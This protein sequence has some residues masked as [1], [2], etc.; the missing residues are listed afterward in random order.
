METGSV[1]DP[2]ENPTPAAISE[3]RVIDDH[4]FM[5][6]EI[7][8]IISFRVTEDLE[9]M[10]K[11]KVTDN[12]EQIVWVPFDN[13]DDRRQVVGWLTR[14]GLERTC[15]NGVKMDH[16][17]HL[18]EAETD[19]NMTV[20]CSKI[21]NCIAQANLAGPKNPPGNPGNIVF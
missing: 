21:E 19:A 9:C 11:V 15:Q 13:I 1:E 2:P 7:D 20:K 14:A 18:I 8:E 4:I 12:V 5:S 6:N 3:V 17:E 16:Y 10:L